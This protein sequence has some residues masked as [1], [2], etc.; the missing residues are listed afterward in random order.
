MNL[1]SLVN[2]SVVILLESLSSSRRADTV[3]EDAVPLVGSIVVMFEDFTRSVVETPRK[4]KLCLALRD[5][6]LSI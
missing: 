3:D 2:Y 6:N 4:I 5:I 1:T